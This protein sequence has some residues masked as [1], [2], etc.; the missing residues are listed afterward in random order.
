MSQLK[1][2]YVPGESG[3]RPGPRVDFP[4]PVQVRNGERL[5]VAFSLGT[6]GHG[7][8]S[9]KITRLALRGEDDALLRE[10]LNPNLGVPH[11]DEE[12][13]VQGL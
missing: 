8:A 9:L 1:G 2:L 11:D 10:F 12:P 7:N 4:G 3:F 13:A 6:D 5:Q